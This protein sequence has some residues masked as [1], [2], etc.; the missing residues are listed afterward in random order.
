MRQQLT[1]G[2]E[3]SCARE[4]R[5]CV[6]VRTMHGPCMLAYSPP[7]HPH[8]THTHMPH[9]QAHLHVDR[10]KLP[11]LAAPPH[12]PERAHKGLGPAVHAQ[13]VAVEEHEGGAAA[14]EGR[15]KRSMFRLC[16]AGTWGSLSAAAV[17]LA[18]L[19]AWAPQNGW[20]GC[21][22]P[23]LTARAARPG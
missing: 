9:T 12:L 16:C 8:T 18:W 23:P 3:K 6:T 20:V 2:L 13:D 22:N 10:H 17:G 11:N 5:C 4:A 14:K 21:T 1:L 19:P 15:W 7:P